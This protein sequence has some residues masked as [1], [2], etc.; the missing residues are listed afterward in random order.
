MKDPRPLHHDALTTASGFVDRVEAASWHRATPCAGWDV[1]ALVAHMT[2][3]NNGFARA[4]KHG[5][6]DRQ[7]YAPHAVAVDELPAAWAASVTTL[8]AA[9][10]QAELD[11]SVRLIEVRPEAALPAAAV[12]RIHLLDTVVHT[13]DLATSIALDYRP[14]DDVLDVV[15]AVTQQIPTGP[16]REGATAAFAPPI[17]SEMPDRWARVLALL[18]RG[19]Q[20]AKAVPG[21]PDLTR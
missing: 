4:L 18:G 16:T 20:S 13:W 19:Q 15:E 14:A 8:G 21:R 9:T 6:A 7:A 5:D 10:D 1:A 12:V 11:R 3:Q 17:P 2:G